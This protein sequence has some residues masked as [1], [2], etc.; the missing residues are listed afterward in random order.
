MRKFVLDEISD[1]DIKKAREYLQEVAIASEV[2]GLYWVDL[3]A[4]VLNGEQCEH[5]ACKPYRF[6]I[7]VCDNSIHFEMLIRSA[8]NMHCECIT[9]AT[10]VQRDFILR[11]GET[12]IGKCNIRT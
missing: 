6:A 9:Y 1:P 5:E 8:T 7:E 12:L 2:E 10:P 11:F 3:P 4:D